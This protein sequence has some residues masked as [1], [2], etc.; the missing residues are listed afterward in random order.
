[1]TDTD[2][3]LCKKTPPKR[4][5]YSGRS[6]PELPRVQESHSSYTGPA[7]QAPHRAARRSRIESVPPT[8][9]A[10]LHGSCLLSGTVRFCSARA[11]GTPHASRALC[12]TYHSR[13]YKS[14]HRSHAHK[15]SA[16]TGN[17]VLIGR[18]NVRRKCASPAMG[19][20]LRAEGSAWHG[21]GTA[22]S[23]MAK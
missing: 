23:L 7:S 13:T 20:T 21:R 22:E 16:A 3:A 17:S 2:S 6:I 9:V 5:A 4:S 1:M 10:A 11:A 8:P 18:R 12:T 19:T 14:D 15:V